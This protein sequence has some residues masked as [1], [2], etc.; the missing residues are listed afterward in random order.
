M[1]SASSVG[2][3]PS[4]PRLPPLTCSPDCKTDLASRPFL[5]PDL[6]HMNDDTASIPYVL[7]ESR[8]V[9]QDHVRGGATTIHSRSRDDPNDIPTHHHKAP[10]LQEYDFARDTSRNA[11]FCSTLSTSYSGTV[12]GVD[13][14]LQH[15]FTHAARRSD[16]SVRFIPKESIDHS[17]ELPGQQQKEMKRLPSSHSMTSSAL[18]ALLPIATAE[19][20]IHT[21]S[22]LPKISFYSPSGNLI[23]P[24]NISPSST[25]TPCSNVNIVGTPTTCTTS[26]NNI[27]TLTA[28][29]LLS[30]AVRVPAARPAPVSMTIPLQSYVPLPGH[31]R[32]HN[33]QHSERSEI[34][35]ESPDLSTIIINRGL[36]VKGC[37]GVVQSHNVWP[38]S[39]VPGSVT[40]A[41]RDHSSRRS[42]SCLSE[43]GM[44]KPKSTTLPSWPASQKGRRLNK[45]VQHPQSEQGIGRKTGHAMRVCFCQPY[46]GTFQRAGARG[47]SIDD[48]D[49]G[50]AFV[51]QAHNIETPNVRIVNSQIGNKVT[52]TGKVRSKSNNKT[53]TDKSIRVCIVGG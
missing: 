14:D 38:Q 10:S 42:L 4:I 41:K 16:T 3:Y 50:E 28:S 7:L 48:Q 33:Y 17:C 13:L 30:A 52:E 35:P 2:I 1:G 12:L 32:H 45:R 31:L 26:Y 23:Q 5:A 47:C 29:N 46:E 24:E 18:S 9:S 40:H 22:N 53:S 37:D 15:D 21:H 19:G 39:A 51:R 44:T 11:S 34:V 36:T 8:N 6:S 49:H 25:K 43:S 20:I 27:R